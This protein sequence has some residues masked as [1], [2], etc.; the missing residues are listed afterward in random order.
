MR[1]RWSHWFSAGW[2]SQHCLRTLSLTSH[3]TPEEAQRIRGRT[4]L[5]GNDT[6]LLQRSKQQLEIRFLKQTLRWSLWIATIRDDDIEF[7]LLVR[8]K[9]EAVPDVC[10]YAWVLEA[11]AH[12][13]Q[14]F[15]GK[16]D[17]GLVDVA[18]YSGLDGGM[19]DDFA[20][21]AAVAATDDED[22][23]GVRVRVHGEVG[24]HLLVARRSSL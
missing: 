24:Y 9:L 10:R 20:E 5:C 3:P 1:E 6:T 8:Q 14:V 18:E 4:T 22:G 11:D 2:N 17:D 23:F 21:N 7:V 13:R 16:A 15:L 12:A 19:L